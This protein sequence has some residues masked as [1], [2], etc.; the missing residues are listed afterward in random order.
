MS[1]S[2]NAYFQAIESVST[3]FS[4]ENS[5]AGVDKIMRETRIFL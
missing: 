5:V 3:V 2:L 1:T 4:E